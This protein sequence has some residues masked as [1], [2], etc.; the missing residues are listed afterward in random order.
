MKLLHSIKLDE[1]IINTEKTFYQG[2]ICLSQNSNENNYLVYSISQYQGLLKVYDVLYLTYVNFISAYK[3]PLFKMCINS[4]GNLL[5][6]C[7]KNNG[8]IKIFN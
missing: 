1:D 3:N 7:C 2:Q 4:K 8:T 5:A 6:S